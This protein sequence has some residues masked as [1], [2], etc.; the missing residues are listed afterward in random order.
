M[1]ETIE[2]PVREQ[3]GANNPPLTPYEQS[4]KEINDLYDE[5]K[6]WL[7]GEP[8]T[9]QAH[10]D[11]L[12]LL[13]GM[14]LEAKQRAETRRKEE[15]KPFDDGKAEVQSR[16]NPLIKDKTG[17]V[18][19]ARDACKK[20]LQPFLDAEQARI[21][22]EAKA[23]REAAEEAQRKAQEALRASTPD[24]LAER[25][26]AEALLTESNK[27]QAAAKKAEGTTAKVSGTGRA[28]SQRT[29]YVAEIMDPIL[30][31]RHYWKIA[32]PEIE[33]FLLSLAQQDVTAGIR[34]IAGVRV[35]EEKTVA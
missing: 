22:A 6:Q 18:D 21:D 15:A 32:Q 12:G 28:L 29:R 10:A 25:E 13:A 34:N 2:M 16:Y 5:A 20:A 19:M 30:V 7:D 11:S 31:V 23:A 3:I 8:I 35:I 9:T 1:S 24:N 33:A 27:L 17:K 26:A 14:L 4:Q